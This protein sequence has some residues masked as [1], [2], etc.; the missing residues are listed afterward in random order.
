MRAE[1]EFDWELGSWLEE[2]E[3]GYRR[4]TGWDHN[5]VHSSAAVAVAAEV[6]EETVPWDTTK[7]RQW[8]QQQQEREWKHWADGRG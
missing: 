5:F 2:R 6:A 8:E 3:K 7:V 4:Q 1:Q